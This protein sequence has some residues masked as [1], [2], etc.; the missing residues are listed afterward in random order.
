MELDRQALSLT[1]IASHTARDP[2]TIRKHIERGLELPALRAA[3]GGRP[4]KITPY[5]DYVREQIVAFHELTATRLM[6][7]LHERGYTCAYTAVK[8][9]VAT[10]LVN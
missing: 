6:R 10:G 5:L 8:R 7:E 1:A 4:N 3:P 9:F 2:K